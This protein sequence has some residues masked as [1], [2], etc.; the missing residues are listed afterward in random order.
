M[1]QFKNLLVPKSLTFET[2]KEAQ[3]EAHRLIREYESLV[4]ELE[5]RLADFGLNVNQKVNISIGD[6]GSGRTLITEDG[7]WSERVRGDWLP[8]SEIC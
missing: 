5:T 7:H 4:S 6:Y 2:Q 8:S 1:S 3:A